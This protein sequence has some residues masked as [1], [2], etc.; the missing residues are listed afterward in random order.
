MDLF[1]GVG[2]VFLGAVMTLI[3]FK[4]IKLF[5]DEQ[6]RAEKWYK[7]FGLLFKIAGLFILCFGL[8]QTALS[9]LS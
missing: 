9:L 6:E 5:Y 1:F 3:G 2:N 7:K 8:L 4:V